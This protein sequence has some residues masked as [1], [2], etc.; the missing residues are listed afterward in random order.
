M[1]WISVLESDL[2]PHRKIGPF[3]ILRP[4]V[5]AGGIVP[6]FL[7][8]PAGHGT[9]LLLEGIG[10]IAGL[11]CGLGILYTMHVY[12]SPKT[13]K[14]VSRAGIGFVAVWTGIVA[15]RALFSYGSFHWFSQQLGRW[16]YTHQVTPYALADA[17]IFMAVAMLLTRT[18]GVLAR[19][20]KARRPAEEGAQVAVGS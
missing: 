11:L 12:R 7:Q 18:V 16:M 5:L 17:L 1:V 10:V 4:V 9:G 19:A 13:G 6:L 14:A 20:A 3:R 8:S 15:A 2:G